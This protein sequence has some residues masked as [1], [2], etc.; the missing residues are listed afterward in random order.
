[1]IKSIEDIIVELSSHMTLEPGDIISTGTPSG[2]GMGFEPPKYLKSGDKVEC[3]IDGI[4]IL[5]NKII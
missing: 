4:G 3:I 2:V 1:M 5:E